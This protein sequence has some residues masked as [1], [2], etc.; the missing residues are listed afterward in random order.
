MIHWLLYNMWLI[1]K[2]KFNV[3]GGEGHGYWTLY[4]QR[5][6]CHARRSEEL[7]W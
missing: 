2:H 5:Q 4:C 3:L 1:G 7:G 6:G